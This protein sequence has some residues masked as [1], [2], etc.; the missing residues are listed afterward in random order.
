M[1]LPTS[2]LQTNNIFIKVI[3]QACMD[4]TYI[5]RKQFI[6]EAKSMITE[7]LAT[8]RLTLKSVSP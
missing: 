3:Y 2:K 5:A 6:T 8:A 4:I 7:N 1:K